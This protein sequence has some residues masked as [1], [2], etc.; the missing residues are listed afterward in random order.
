MTRQEQQAA[1]HSCRSLCSDIYSSNAFAW[2]AVML[3]VNIAGSQ[4]VAG[5]KPKSKLC[6]SVSTACRLLWVSTAHCYLDT[7]TSYPSS[8]PS[9]FCPAD[10]SQQLVWIWP[11]S[12]APAVPERER[13][14]H[15]RVV[16]RLCHESGTAVP[17][18]RQGC[19]RTCVSRAHSRRT[20]CCSAWQ[21]R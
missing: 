12:H 4:P 5:S 3:Q 20:T 8:Q 16:G 6:A 1:G 15:W 14:S 7:V 17:A 18:A 2:T 9:D 13:I 21:V 11:C 19:C 10:H